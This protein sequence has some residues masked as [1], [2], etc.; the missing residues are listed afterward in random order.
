[1]RDAIVA[2]VA[3]ALW[4]GADTS[5]PFRTVARGDNSK[6]GQ[7]HEFVV[8]TAGRWQLIWWEHTGS[9]EFPP[10]DFSRDMVIAVFGGTHTADSLE[11]DSLQIVSVTREGGVLAVRYQEQRA[12]AGARIAGAATRPFHIITVAGDRSEVRFI[13]LTGLNRSGRL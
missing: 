13:S 12:E 3:V 5:V 7:H 1:M 9:Y 4:S 6:V 10:V 8:R 11:A 2:V